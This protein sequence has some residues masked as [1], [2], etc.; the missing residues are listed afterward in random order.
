[1]SFGDGHHRCPGGPLALMETEVFLTHLL[2]RD[3]VADGPPSARWNAVTQ[4][5]ELKG[6]QVRLRS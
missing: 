6:F 2:S 5:Y 3:L 4:G 1:M